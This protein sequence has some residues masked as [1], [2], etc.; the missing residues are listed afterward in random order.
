MEVLGTFRC[1]AV[2]LSYTVYFCMLMQ[3]VCVYCRTGSLDFMVVMAVYSWWL[4]ILSSVLLYS[5]LALFAY[6]HLKSVEYYSL[7]LVVIS[8]VTDIY[9]MCVSGWVSCAC[10][11]LK[12]AEQEELEPGKAVHYTWTEPTGSRELCWKCGTYSGKLKSEKVL[13]CT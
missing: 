7:I 8:N 10:S 13:S 3:I 2:V 1:L 9:S 11:S 12:E 6:C 5:H 4:V